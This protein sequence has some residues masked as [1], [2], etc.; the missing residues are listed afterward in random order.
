M[1]SKISRTYYLKE[2]E[3]KGWKSNNTIPDVFKNVVKLE[4]LQVL[5]RNL[6][7]D[8]IRISVVGI[9]IGMAAMTRLSRF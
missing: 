1:N 7:T 8:D 3:H 9:R 2:H 5:G 4:E 6:F